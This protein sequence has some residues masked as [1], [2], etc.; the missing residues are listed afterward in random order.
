MN[1]FL[2]I[3][4]SLSTYI[5]IQKYELF[6]P[7]ESGLNETSHWRLSATLAVPPRLLPENSSS[8]FVHHSVQYEEFDSRCMEFYGNSNWL[9][10]S[11]TLKNIGQ[12]DYWKNKSHVPNH[13]PGNIHVQCVC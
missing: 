8:Q 3:R 7:H 4:K 5:N 11:T 13:Q 10:V 9:V 2:Y 6:H 12:W 1:Y